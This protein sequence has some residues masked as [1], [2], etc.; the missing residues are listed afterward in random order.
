MSDRVL[1]M[2]EG[3]QIGDLRARRGDEER[4]I[5]RGDGGR[6]SALLRL[7]PERL[8]EL[9]LL[10][11]LAVAV[12]IFSQLIDNYLR[13]QLLQPRHDERRD[14]RDPRRRPDDR[15]PD[16]EHRPVGRL[17]R[18]RHGVRHRRVPARPPEPGARARGRLR[19]RHR[20][21]PRPPQRRA[22]RLRAACP[23]SSSRSARWRSSARWLVN[24]SNSQTITVRRAA[25]TGCSTSRTRR[26]SASA[27]WDIR[28]VVAGAVV[29]ILVLQL[30]LG[31]AQ[32]GPL[33]LRGRLQP[34]RGRA[35]PRCRSSA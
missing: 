18:R 10:L 19:G 12:L 31:G 26:W 6:M 13:R 29:L 33:G 5:T 8:R 9:S 2:R 3:R 14:H 23:R 24:H 27:S 7:R 21:R 25:A 11:V 20:R 22:R 35:R 28:T 4:I 30:L 32:M 15:D 16:A 17:D 1:V 34:G